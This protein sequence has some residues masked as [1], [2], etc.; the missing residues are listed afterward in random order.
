MQKSKCV[1]EVRG[2]SLGSRETLYDGVLDAHAI[3]E[4]YEKAAS[5]IFH[6]VDVRCEAHNIPITQMFDLVSE[7]CWASSNPTRAISSIHATLTD[8]YGNVVR[9]YRDV[10]PATGTVSRSIIDEVER[11]LI[12][13]VLVPCTLA[14]YLPGIH[15]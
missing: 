8:D 11:E 6:D 7:L 15:N 2:R 10:S 12:T 1:V 9:V 4:A 5:T 3:A 14:S 13:R